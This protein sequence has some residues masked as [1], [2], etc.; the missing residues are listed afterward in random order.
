METHG[1]ALGDIALSM[2][3]GFQP[4]KRPRLQA[5]W[6]REGYGG[7]PRRRALYREPLQAQNARTM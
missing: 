2:C 6:V 7:L 1:S 4:L 3:V 5:V